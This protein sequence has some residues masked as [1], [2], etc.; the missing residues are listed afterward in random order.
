MDTNFYVVYLYFD[1][2]IK[3][4]LILV[5]IPTEFLCFSLL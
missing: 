1:F 2:Q 5:K 4:I 3:K